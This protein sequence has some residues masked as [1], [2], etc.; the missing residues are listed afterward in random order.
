MSKTQFLTLLG[1]A[2]ARR[3]FCERVIARLGQRFPSSRV[4]KSLCWHTGEALAQQGGDLNR[5]ALLE[6]GVRLHLT[7]EEPLLRSAYFHGS[8]EPDTSL[9]LKRLVKPGQTWLD[10]GANIG[11]FTVLIARLVGRDGRVFAYEPNPHLSR[12]LRH[13]LES[14]AFDH[15]NLRE[16]ALADTNGSAVLHIPKRPAA[17]PGG[18][19]RASLLSQ[20]S[21]PEVELHR[22]SLARLDDNLPAGIAVDG[23]KIDVEGYEL[24][25]FKGMSERLKT[26]P[27]GAILFEA[28]RL[29][30]GLA[31]PEQLVI[32]LAS[33]HYDCYRAIDLTQVRLGTRFSGG[34]CENI[35]AI[36]SQNGQLR[37]ELGLNT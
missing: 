35:L 29:D 16:I 26:N 22:V 32:F 23:I 30:E 7:L 8:H 3:P 15:V 12:M 5:I 25:V 20:S 14:N 2:V 6:G 10:I 17:T 24:A 18:S 31:T 34:L 11:A 13:S 9:M 33:F 28:S 36:A 37:A 19:G 4:I 27:P 1:N 21:L